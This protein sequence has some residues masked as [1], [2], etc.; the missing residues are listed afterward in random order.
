MSTTVEFL[1]S[2]RARD[3]RVWVED[4]RLRVS[5]RAGAL[6]EELKAALTAR[7]DEILEWLRAAAALRNE[8]PAIV[9]IK[10]SGGRPPVFAVPGHNGDVFCYLTFARYLHVDQPLFGVQPPGLDG[11][12]PPASIEEFA[13][14]EVEQILRYRPQGPFLLV[15]YCAGG[16]IAFEVA[17]QL[18]RRGHRVAMLGL[19]GS[20][21]PSAYRGR[22]R[23]LRLTKAAA[24]YGRHLRAL[25]SSPLDGLAYLRAT[26][27]RRQAER[28]KADA[29]LRDSALDNR[30]RVERATL[31]A[32]AGYTP[33][34]WAGRIDLFL[35]T[36]RWRTHLGRPLDWTLLARSSS[37]VCGPEDGRLDRMLREPFAEGTAR[38][39]S[40]RL[41][42]IALEG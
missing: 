6:D 39:L 36:P 22:F 24:R 20:L 19:L 8:S 21:F 2:L 3:I 12:E 14:Y 27:E 30:R 32:I 16:T 29:D 7:R 28:A 38:L 23:M 4:G 5:A 41:D 15:G 31:E 17:Q 35:P 26:A 42:E 1:A 18:V 40:T 9:P 33:Q 37:V 10:P 11:S 34:P 13:R 25:L